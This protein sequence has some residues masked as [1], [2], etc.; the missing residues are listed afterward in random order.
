MGADGGMSKPDQRLSPGARLILSGSQFANKRGIYLG[1]RSTKIHVALY[2][3]TKGKVGG[4]PPGFPNV[5]IVLVDHVGAKTGARRTSPLMYHEENG[6]VAVAASKAGEPTHPAWFHNL[7]AHP[8]TTIQIGAEVRKVRA[9]VATD[10]ER[11]DWWPR[12]VKKYPGYE[13]FQQRAKDREIP[14]VLF[15]PASTTPP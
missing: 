6:V 9:R 15:E 3:K 2:R 10:D 11:A 5:P 1:R 13:F 7:M 14:V 12:L 8:D 4:R